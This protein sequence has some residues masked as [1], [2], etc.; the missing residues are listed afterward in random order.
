MV[1][2]IANTPSVTGAVAFFTSARS[3]FSFNTRAG[4]LQGSKDPADRAIDSLVSV[5]AETDPKAARDLRDQWTLSREAL[6]RTRASAKT[7]GSERKAAARAKVARLKSQLMALRMRAA[8][9]PEGAAREAARLAREL[10]SAAREYA[11]AGGGAAAGS[12]L[13][14]GTMTVVLP[15]SSAPTGGTGP[16]QDTP[17]ATA[18]MDTA[19]TD[20]AATT[21]APPESPAPAAA[22]PDAEAPASD[23]GGDG[24]GSG[25]TTPPAATSG[26]DPSKVDGSDKSENGDENR[27]ENGK[28]A[29]SKQSDEKTKDSEF[30]REVRRLM[31]E[32]RNIIED[33]KR[34]LRQES[35][36]ESQDIKDAENA[37]GTVR[38]ALGQIESGV[39]S[40]AP[41]TTATTATAAVT[42]SPSVDISV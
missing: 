2:M 15:T 34:R 3:V 14:G 32:L 22:P 1:T 8:V 16:A 23:A 18:A 17:G 30:A 20:T 7:S 21:T 33:A 38:L 36:S 41:L 24:E 12:A 26:D 6:D 5:I 28:V 37:L 31:D 39:T 13:G 27:T 40:T 25:G 4:T 11:S 29:T 19:P 42:T 9:D 10:A 35:S